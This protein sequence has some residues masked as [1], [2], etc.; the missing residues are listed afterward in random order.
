MWP[1]SLSRHLDFL[2][3]PPP[4][5]E[6]SIHLNRRVLTRLVWNHEMPTNQFKNKPNERHKSRIARQIIFNNKKT[7]DKRQKNSNGLT[8]SQQLITHSSVSPACNVLSLSLLFSQY[9]CV[10]VCVTLSKDLQARL[11]TSFLLWFGI[12]SEGSIFTGR[13]GEPPTRDY[14]RHQLAD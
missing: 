3:S 11:I 6:L 1:P 13:V 5:R 8:C 12:W 10:C 9:V 7:E 4:T 14:H 2:I